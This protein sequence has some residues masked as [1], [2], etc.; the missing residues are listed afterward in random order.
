MYTNRI[1]YCS[2]EGLKK[3][4]RIRTARHRESVVVTGLRTS[5]SNL[6]VRLL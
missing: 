5:Y 3:L 6:D 4:V 2:Q 1:S